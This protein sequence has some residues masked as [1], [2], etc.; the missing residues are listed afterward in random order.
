LFLG[1]EFAQVYASRYGTRIVPTPNAVPIDAPEPAKQHKPKGA[2]A[3]SA[4][5]KASE[6]NVTPAQRT[7]AE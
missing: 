2:D 5:P 4:S 1:A 3:K 6:P 7:P